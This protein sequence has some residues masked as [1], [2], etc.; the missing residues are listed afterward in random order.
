MSSETPKRKGLLGIGLIGTNKEAFNEKEN[1]TSLINIEPKKLKPNP[2]QPR[3]FFDDEYIFSLSESIKKY[4]LLQPVVVCKDEVD[5]YMILAGENRVRAS[6]L[7]NINTIKAIVTQSEEKDFLV[8][9]L[10]ENIVRKD[11]H[12]I[13]VGLGLQGLMVKNN[14]KTQNELIEDT[15]FH[16]GTIS[17]YLSLCKLSIEAQSIIL[18]NGL[19]D[20]LILSLISKR[21]DELNQ[22]NVIEY[23][24]ENKLTRD[25]SLS[26]IRSFLNDKNLS[27]K[28]TKTS[29][30]SLK[31]SK[32]KLS[33]SFDFR[34]I[35]S[36][37]KDEFQKK[38]KQFIENYINKEK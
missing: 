37:N 36:I 7:A 10:V 29:P 4:G 19:R 1:N 9:A 27:A 18:K 11:L 3:L 2:Q 6:I 8:K 15:K 5:E 35:S 12:P 22:V 24:V 20:L 34:Q 25:D 33:L 13:E 38:L 17:R 23:I 30:Y 28:K 31:S 32:T 16:K 21:I 26:Y 14:Y